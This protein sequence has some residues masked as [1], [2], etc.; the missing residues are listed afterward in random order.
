MEV[1]DFSCGLGAV[2]QGGRWGFINKKGKE[3]IE[4]K[5]D[6]VSRF[7]DGYAT[8]KMGKTFGLI[9]TDGNLVINTQWFYDIV[10]NNSVFEEFI[11]NHK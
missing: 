11:E 1:L 8:V 4:L 3:V 7:V 2:N 9:D 6:A 10:I 5:Y